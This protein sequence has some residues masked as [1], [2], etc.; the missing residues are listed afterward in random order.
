MQRCAIAQC[1]FQSGLPE[2]KI[3]WEIGAAVYIFTAVLFF[4]WG[5]GERQEWNDSGDSTVFEDNSKAASQQ[6]PETEI[7]EKL[8]HQ[9]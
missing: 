2:W 9:K 4:M 7:A 6:T 5:T 3:I 1:H 8:E